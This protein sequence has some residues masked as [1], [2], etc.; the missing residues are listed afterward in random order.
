[1]NPTL[2][3]RPN[4]GAAAELRPVATALQASVEAVRDALAHMDEDAVLA[5]PVGE[6]H[7]NFAVVEWCAG[8]RKPVI[9][10]FEPWPLE[11]LLVQN[12]A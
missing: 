8:N 3:R 9:N 10:R 7:Q 6:P 1:M 11:H 5:V 4:R 12:A 2:I